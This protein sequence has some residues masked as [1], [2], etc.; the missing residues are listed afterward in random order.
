[1]WTKAGGSPAA[2]TGPGPEIV[3]TVG[4]GGFC[5]FSERDSGY[6]ISTEFG[7]FNAL[8]C[9]LV[10]K[11]VLWIGKASGAALSKGGRRSVK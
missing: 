2:G 1:V 11:I 3:V 9:K 6:W 7:L 5:H 8:S 4:N 10:Q